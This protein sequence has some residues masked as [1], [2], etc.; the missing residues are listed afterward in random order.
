M[1]SGSGQAVNGNFR[2]QVSDM[3]SLRNRSG[4]QVELFSGQSDICLLWREDAGD[5]F[6]ICVSTSSRQYY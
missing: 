3:L 5:L 2:R 6:L 4:L 1:C